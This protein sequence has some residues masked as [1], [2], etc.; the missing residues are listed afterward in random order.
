M[1]P[2]VYKYLM[3]VNVRLR[4]AQAGSGVGSYEM[5]FFV[6]IGCMLFLF[7]NQAKRVL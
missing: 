2:G 6:W 4:L 3:P 7:T 5:Y 1:L